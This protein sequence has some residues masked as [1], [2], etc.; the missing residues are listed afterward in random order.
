MFP[1]SGVLSGDDR[2]LCDGSYIS[3]LASLVRDDFTAAVHI[4][5]DGGTRSPHAQISLQ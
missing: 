3:H 5:A 1:T 2:D 4:D